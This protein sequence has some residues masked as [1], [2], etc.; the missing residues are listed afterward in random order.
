M[1]GDALKEVDIFTAGLDVVERVCG[2]C[3]GA[4]LKIVPKRDHQHNP[5]GVVCKCCNQK[6]WVNGRYGPLRRT[7]AAADEDEEQKLAKRSMETYRAWL[8]RVYADFFALLPPCPHCSA[9]D[10][11][12]YNVMEPIPCPHCGTVGNI[13]EVRD[14][15]SRHYGDTVWWFGP[16]VI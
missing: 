13:A 15:T 4:H 10:Y 6:L 7:S 14:V 12:L 3:N 11:K 2:D 8:E 16:L 5:L 9:H 1:N